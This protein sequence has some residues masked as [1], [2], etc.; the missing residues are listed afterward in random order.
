MSGRKGKK[1]KERD[2]NKQ[3]KNRKDAILFLLLNVIKIKS[4]KIVY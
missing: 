4:L 2:R 3:F 1:E